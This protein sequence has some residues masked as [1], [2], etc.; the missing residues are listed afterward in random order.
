MR[1]ERSLFWFVT[2]AG[3]IGAAAALVCIGLYVGGVR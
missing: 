3:S 1:L 2:V